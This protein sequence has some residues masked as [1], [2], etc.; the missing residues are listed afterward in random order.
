MRKGYF[1]SI[2]EN[3]N[4]ENG[5]I[6]FRYNCIRPRNDSEREIPPIYVVLQPYKIEFYAHYTKSQKDN[7]QHVNISILKLPLSENLA[8]ID[9]LSMKLKELYNREISIDGYTHNCS[10]GKSVKTYSDLMLDKLAGDNKIQLS[11]LLLDFLF[12]LEHGNIF[13]YSPIYELVEVKL[14][15]NII[16]SAIAAKANYKYLRAKVFDYKKTSEEA[17]FYIHELI[18]AEKQW[19]NIIRNA[20]AYNNLSNNK[21]FET[22]EDEYNDVLFSKEFPRSYWINLYTHKEQNDENNLNILKESSRWYLRRYNLKRGFFSLFAY[23]DQKYTPYIALSF[24][25]IITAIILSLISPE[26]PNIISIAVYLGLGLIPAIILFLISYHRLLLPF[27]SALLPRLLMAITSAWIIF[28]TT[29]EIV[30]SSFDLTLS[31]N[32]WWVLLFFIPIFLFIGLEI[33]NLGPDLLSSDILKRSVYIITL[34]F[35]YSFL[36]G[37]FFMN[38]VQG[39]ILERSGY[40][41]EFLLNEM[42]N[43]NFKVDKKLIAAAIFNLD[44]DDD[45][46]EHFKG[47]DMDDIIKAETVVQKF[48]EKEKVSYSSLIHKKLKYLSLVLTKHGSLIDTNCYKILKGETKIPLYKNLDLVTYKNL[49]NVESKLKYHVPLAFISKDCVIDIFPGL[50]LIRTFFAL[51][52]G[53]FIQLIFEDKPI[54]EPL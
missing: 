53:I 24:I 27:A 13:Q 49:F 30:K 32:H 4:Y 9:N 51:F 43:E 1:F 19:L 16:F 23:K 39:D 28:E 52:I 15:E 11:R 2:D 42:E 20:E 44:D 45:R 31:F 38:T 33:K 8:V 17:Q 47:Y 10:P 36:V 3:A 18:D 41:D 46:I 7:E 48:G 50:L 26:P 6:L 35:L 34:G 21:W 54:T 14:K 25:L 37:I 5:D 29:E 22:L 40:L 12:D